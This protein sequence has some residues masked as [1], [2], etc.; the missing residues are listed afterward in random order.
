MTDL[1]P[2]ARTLRADVGAGARKGAAAHA[3]ARAGCV[4]FARVALRVTK[5]GDQISPGTGCWTAMRLSR[6]TGPAQPV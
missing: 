1:T 3:A 4:A 2:C 6:M 5:D